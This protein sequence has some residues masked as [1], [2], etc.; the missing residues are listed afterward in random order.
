MEAER[1]LL[2]AKDLCAALSISL[3]SV[4]NLRAAGKLP[5]PVRLGGSVRWRRSDIV[6]WISMSCPNL[7]K[8]EQR[9]GALR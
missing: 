7:E 5:A 6:D 8:F 4:Y 1:L 3:A 2:C 9:R